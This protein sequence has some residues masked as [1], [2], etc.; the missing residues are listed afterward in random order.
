MDS[1]TIKELMQGANLLL[2]VL[3]KL[4]SEDMPQAQKEQI[5]K[6]QKQAK[7]EMKKIK[8]QINSI[9]NFDKKI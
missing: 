8:E 6:A 9:A 4:K 1:N 2:N 3:D 7:E 5:D